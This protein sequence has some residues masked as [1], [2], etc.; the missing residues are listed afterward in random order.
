[1][2]FEQHPAGGDDVFRLGAEQADGLDVLEQP[3]FAEGEHG[4][5]CRGDRE[6]TGGRLVHADVRCL[7][8]QNDRNQQLKRGGVVQ[9]GRRCRVGF[10]QAGV[11]LLDL[12]FFHG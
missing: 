1:M 7:G 10:A 12:G 8:G 6:K 9:F 4:L 11:E 2:Q 5:R 3:F